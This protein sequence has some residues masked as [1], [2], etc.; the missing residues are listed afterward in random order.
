MIIELVGKDL[1]AYMDSRVTYTLRG[2]DM[3]KCMSLC[4]ENLNTE[5][6]I[7]NMNLGFN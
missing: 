3:Q 7:L 4:L 6:P 5:I 1:G 2:K